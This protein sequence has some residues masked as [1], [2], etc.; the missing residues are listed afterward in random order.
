VAEETRFWAAV[1]TG[2]RATVE[3]LVLA[4]P[5]LGLARCDGVSAI[6]G[7]AAWS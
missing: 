4:S 6:L 1:T 5:D 2:D 7:S 3:S